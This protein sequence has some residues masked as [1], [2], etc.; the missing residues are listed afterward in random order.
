MIN[1]LIGGT[2][3]ANTYSVKVTVV[4][5]NPPN[6]NLPWDGLTEFNE[7]LYNAHENGD[8]ALGKTESAD[9]LIVTRDMRDR[10]TAEEWKTK[11]EALIA[12][13]GGQESHKIASY[14]IEDII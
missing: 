1:I 10:A 7:M 13:Y 11:V 9:G 5:E 3:M 2:I 6:K 12:K 4:W 14:T 8:V